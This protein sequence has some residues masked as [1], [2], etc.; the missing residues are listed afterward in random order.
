[1]KWP[2]ERERVRERAGER[3]RERDAESE[4]VWFRPLAVRGDLLSQRR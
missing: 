1:M 4:C 2:V 3:E